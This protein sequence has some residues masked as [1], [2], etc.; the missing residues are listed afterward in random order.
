MLGARIHAEYKKN[1]LETVVIEQERN[2]TKRVPE[3][4]APSHDQ[5]HDWVYFLVQSGEVWRVCRGRPGKR[6]LWVLRKYSGLEGCM[7]ALRG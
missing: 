7:T 5:R 4:Y 1:K 3:P 6:A 2:R